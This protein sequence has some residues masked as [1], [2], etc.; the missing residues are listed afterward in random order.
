MKSAEPEHAVLN[1][2]R[3]TT[4]KHFQTLK[5][6]QQVSASSYLRNNSNSRPQPPSKKPLPNSVRQSHDIGQ[7]SS[8]TFLK[9][10]SEAAPPQN[11]ERATSQSANSSMQKGGK[12]QNSK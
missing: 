4:N 5:Q 2:P 10:H 1:I 3:S 8:S 9:Q 6:N 7:S 11:K 12:V